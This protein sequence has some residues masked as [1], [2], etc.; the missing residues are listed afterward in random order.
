MRTFIGIFPP[1]EIQQQILDTLPHELRKSQSLRIEERSKLHCTLHFLG[2]LTNQQVGEAIRRMALLDF[3]FSN[4]LIELRSFGVFPDLHNPRILWISCENRSLHSVYDSIKKTLS[5]LGLGIEPGDFRF[6][7][8]ITIG[9]VK[10]HQHANLGTLRPLLKEFVNSVTLQSVVFE[11]NSLSF[12][13][14][15]ISSKGST[16][17]V[18]QHFPFIQQTR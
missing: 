5:P 6:I 3:P 9:R 14:S 4:L 17:E 15:I 12:M 13:Q 2:E 16:Y 18:I 8:H 7:P 11:A 1:Q 10:R